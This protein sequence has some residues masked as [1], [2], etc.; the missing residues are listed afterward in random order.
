MKIYTKKGDEGNTQL[1]GG[2]K[3]KKSAKRLNAYGTVDELNS[4][5]GIIISEIKLSEN[6]DLKSVAKII[7]R[8]QSNL[9]KTGS[10]LASQ[11]NLPKAMEN[12][13]SR[14]NEDNI[15]KLEEEIDEWEKSLPKLTKF[16]LPGGTKIA[17]LVHQA[18]TVCR[19]AERV[20]VDLSE[21]DEINLMVVKYLNRMSDWLFVMA[22]FV[23]YTEGVEDE[24]SLH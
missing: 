22:R 11:M 15:E 8:E 17:S 2:V 5:L 18:R 20:T 23:N 12:K 6:Q 9:L 16:I 19:R 21:E 3:V 4:I 13:I 14:I 24:F 1:F 7:K 10:D